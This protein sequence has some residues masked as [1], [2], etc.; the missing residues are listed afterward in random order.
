VMQ[1]TDF[2]KF[3]MIPPAS[4]SSTGLMSGASLSSERCV[5]AR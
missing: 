5:R 1:A 3:P 2:G 4:G